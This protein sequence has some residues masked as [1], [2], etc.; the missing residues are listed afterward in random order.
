MISVGGKDKLVDERWNLLDVECVVAVG[1]KPTKNL[2]DVGWRPAAR[3]PM[4]PWC[5]VCRW[6]VYGPGKGGT[7]SGNALFRWRLG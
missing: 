7:P 5:R 2:V 4:A 6:G 3:G 1:I